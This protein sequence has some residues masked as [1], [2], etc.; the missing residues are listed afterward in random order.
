MRILIPVPL[1]PV[2]LM[3]AL[4]SGMILV[5]FIASS[6]VE[7]R[8]LFSASPPRR[9]PLTRKSELRTSGNNLSVPARKLRLQVSETP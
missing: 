7:G 2:V 3:W 4:L 9:I 8:R 6:L 5:G 1:K